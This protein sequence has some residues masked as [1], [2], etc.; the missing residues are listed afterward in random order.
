MGISEE[1]LREFVQLAQ[2]R[3]AVFDI[4]SDPFRL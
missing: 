1:Q 2:K 4:V 3:S